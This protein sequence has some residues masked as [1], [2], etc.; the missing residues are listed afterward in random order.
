MFGIEVRGPKF[1]ISLSGPLCWIAL[2]GPMFWIALKGPLCWIALRG[3]TFWIALKGP[4]FWIALRG[5]TFWIALHYGSVLNLGSKHYGS[6]FNF[7]FFNQNKPTIF[8]LGETINME[9]CNNQFWEMYMPK[10]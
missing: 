3:P 5:P 2:K 10:R 6:G 4:R 8:F 1:G 7:L 9:S